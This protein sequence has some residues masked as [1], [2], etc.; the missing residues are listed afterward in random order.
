MLSVSPSIRKV[1]FSLFWRDMWHKILHVA[2][3]S[4]LP[5]NRV[6][7][8]LFECCILGPYE[9]LLPKLIQIAATRLYSKDSAGK[10]AHV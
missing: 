8:E 2:P 3:P 9:F 1:K 4:N 7:Y 5:Y 6:N 10:V